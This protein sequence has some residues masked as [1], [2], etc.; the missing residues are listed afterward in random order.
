MANRVTNSSIGFRE[1]LANSYAIF[2]SDR[3]SLRIS[4][5]P[6]EKPCVALH[7]YFLCVLRLPAL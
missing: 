6:L 3:L 4:A 5:A 2:R 1:L 7:F